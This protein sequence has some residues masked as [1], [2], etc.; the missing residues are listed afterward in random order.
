[1][2]QVHATI[3]LGLKITWCFGYGL[4]HKC[5]IWQEVNKE[6]HLLHYLLPL[7]P[8]CSVP[9]CWPRMNNVDCRSMQPPKAWLQP[10]E[11]VGVYSSSATPLA[12]C[13]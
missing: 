11:D 5:S 12:R 10:L 13:G 3:Y 8:R 4:L 7:P 2:G 9:E 1:M 6:R